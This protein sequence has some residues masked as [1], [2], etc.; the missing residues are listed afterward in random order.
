MIGGAALIASWPASSAVDVVGSGPDSG[1]DLLDLIGA[2]SMTAMLLIGLA[3]LVV[4]LPVVRRRATMPSSISFAAIGVAA[5]SLTIARILIHDLAVIVDLPDAGGV[6]PIVQVTGRVLEPLVPTE[7]ALPG[8]SEMDGIDAP[9]DARTRWRTTLRIDAASHPGLEGRRLV[10]GF[11]VDDPRLVSGATITVTGRLA[12]V[13]PPLNPGERDRRRGRRDRV[14]AMLVVPSAGLVSVVGERSTSTGSAWMQAGRAAWADAVRSVEREVARHRPSA[15]GIVEAILLGDR[16]HLDEAVRRAAEDAGVAPMLAISGWH[17][18][19]IAG[20][21]SIVLGRHRPIGR[22]TALAAVIAFASVVVP[23]AGVRRASMMVVISGAALLVGRRGRG[24][25]IVLL[26][27]AA[28]VWIDPTIAR[29]AGFRLSMVATIALV[30]GAAGARR[31]WFGPPDAVGRRGVSFLRDRFTL[32][33]GA[34]IVAWTSTAPI[35]LA[36]FGRLSLVGIPA[37][38]LLAPVFTVFVLVATVSV[39]TTLLIGA[40]PDVAARAT[41]VLGGLFVTAIDSVAAVAPIWR[42]PMS[43]IAVDLAIGP[44]ILFVVSFTIEQT[45]WRRGL[46]AAGVLSVAAMVMVARV[47]VAE[48]ADDRV[49]LDAIAVGDGTAILVRG[50]GVA[51]LQ[52]AGSSSVAEA[53]RRII[54]PTLRSLGVRRL[55]AIVVTH[56]NADH[57][58]AVT[59]LVRAFPVDRVVVTP[60]LLR[61]ARED[62]G[63]PIGTWLDRM[64]DADVA[65]VEAVRGD[66]FRFG[67]LVWTVLHPVRAERCRSVNDESLMATV[68]LATDPADRP[69]LLLC[70]DVQDEAIARLMSREPGLRATVMELPHHG[71]WRPIAAALLAEVDPVAI[72][73]STGPDRWWMDRWKDACAGRRRGVTC[74]DG[75]VSI[76]IDAAGRVH[77]AGDRSEEPEPGFVPAVGGAT[78]GP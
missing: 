58:N 21:A 55:D 19:I 41:A 12:M 63:S 76:E 68:R 24:V 22:W 6:D 1:S 10:T 53:G 38:I 40:C 7:S 17:L 69:R 20:F 5:T 26:A 67:E 31:R 43:M 64:H 3:I 33:A 34:S 51:V 70:G 56:A 9:P 35:V 23:G 28:L 44:A 4:G 37:A 16:R 62:R 13:P 57:F 29:S 78:V 18:A 74:R 60:H 2:M 49:R 73:Q 47:G 39:V 45:W 14:P 66:R 11:D 59:D 72:V 54:V 71:S 36:T 48:P 75:L 52:D 42:Q 25:P 32:V 65:V 77:P 15:R 27:G 30:A 8:I 61:R 50:G 46:G